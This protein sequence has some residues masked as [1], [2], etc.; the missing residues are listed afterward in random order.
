MEVARL[1]NDAGIICICS[2]IAPMERMRKEARE[3]IGEERFF[4]VHL[5]APL[6]VCQQRHGK[7]LY[8]AVEEGQLRN[9]PGKTTPYEVP[10][11]P[12]L[13][14]ETQKL[15]PEECTERIIQVIQK[16]GVL[17]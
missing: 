11:S 3:R 17:L 15:T 4:L 12:D 6:D 14:I 5:D 8:A 16:K 13:R 9:V 1:L 7:G 2:L 10:A